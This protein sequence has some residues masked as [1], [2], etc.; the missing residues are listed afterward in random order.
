[1][2]THNVEKSAQ[3]QRTGDEYRCNGVQQT[4]A[5]CARARESSNTYRRCSA[6]CLSQCV[7]AAVHPASSIKE[8][9]SRNLHLV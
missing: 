3:F 9:E 6:A 1:M 8:R 7:S 2:N 4:E 5:V